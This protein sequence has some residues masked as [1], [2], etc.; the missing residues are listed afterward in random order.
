MH[1]SWDFLCIYNLFLH[2]KH[3]WV[4][5]VQTVF[6]LFLFAL[7]FT[8]LKQKHLWSLSRIRERRPLR[9]K[10]GWK[11]WLPFCIPFISLSEVRN[12]KYHV[13][14]GVRNRSLGLCLDLG[15]KPGYPVPVVTFCPAACQTRLLTKTS[16]SILLKELKFQYDSFIYIALIPQTTYSVPRTVG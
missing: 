7:S 11:E 1:S 5:T 8:F 2:V 15:I 10:L 14:K 12:P 16:F 4:H 3:K 6:W 13:G 9:W